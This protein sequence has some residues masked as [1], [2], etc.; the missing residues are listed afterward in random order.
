[1]GLELEY[2]FAT[3]AA[4]KVLEPL[5]SYMHQNVCLPLLI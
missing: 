1:M 4:R 5:E 2:I 3:K